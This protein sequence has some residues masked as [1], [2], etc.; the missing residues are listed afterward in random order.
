MGRTLELWMAGKGLGTSARRLVEAVGTIRS[1]DVSV[2]VKRG[3]REV[4]PRLRTGARPDADV[5]QLLAHIGLRLPKGS[6]LVEN[7]VEKAVA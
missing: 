2:P 7:V 5:A 3:D 1:M 4:R 6:R